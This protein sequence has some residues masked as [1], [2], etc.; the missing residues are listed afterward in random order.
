VGIIEN[1]A[2]CNGEL[3]VTIFAV[4]ELLFGFQ[5]DGGSLAARAFRAPRPA[6]TDK[7]FAAFLF[8]WEQGMNVN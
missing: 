2:R 4:E 6:E 8:A 1:R 3:I 5:F 7:Q